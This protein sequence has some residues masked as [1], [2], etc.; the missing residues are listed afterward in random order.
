MLRV[1]AVC[2]NYQFVVAHRDRVWYVE[3]RVMLLL[4]RS[5]RHRRVVER[6]AKENLVAA[7]TLQPNQRIVCRHLRIITIGIGLRQPVQLASGQPIG[8]SVAQ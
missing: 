3:M 1:D 5:D 6:A 4:P 2:D 8:V 7:N